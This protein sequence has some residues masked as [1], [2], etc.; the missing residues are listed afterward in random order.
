MFSICYEWSPLAFFAASIL[1]LVDCFLNENYINSEKKK[2]GEIKNLDILKNDFE[3]CL[4]IAIDF[5]CKAISCEG[6]LNSF[7]MCP[8]YQTFMNSTLDP[9]G[10]L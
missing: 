4:K 3:K 10:F 1:T 9:S 8:N 2:N 5:I 6:T 7:F